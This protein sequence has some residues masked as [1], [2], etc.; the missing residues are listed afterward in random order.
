MKTRDIKYLNKD[1]NS[2]NNTLEQ[3]LKTYFPNTYQDFNPESIG[4]MFIE[5]SSYVGDVLAF[6]LDNQIQENFPQLARKIENLFKHAYVRGYKPKV[7]TPSVSE[8]EIFQEVPYKIVNSER[9]PN[10]EYSLLIPENTSVNSDEIPEINFLT[11]EPIDFGYSSSFDPTI[12][13]ISQIDS[14]NKPETF[15][16]TKKRKIISAKI[17]E[18]SFDV[19]DYERFPSFEINDNNIICILDVKDSDNNVWY[20]V[21]NLS[22]NL[23]PEYIRNTE[24]REFNFNQYKDTP[25]MLRYK[26]IQRRFTSRFKDYNSLILEFGSG[27]YTETDENITPNPYN[28]GINYPYN[29]SGFGIAYSPVNFLF[30]KSYGIA[31]NNTTLTIRYLVGGGVESNIPKNTLNNID[32]TNVS[33]SSPIE[34]DNNILNTLTCNNIEPSTGGSDGDSV[35]DLRIKSMAQ[36]S[37]Q[38]R[39]VSEQDYVI[40]S[41][42]MPPRLGSISKAYIKPENVEEIEDGS[43]QLGLYILGFDNNKKLIKSSKALKQ[44]LKNYLYQYNTLNDLILIK[45]AYIINVGVDF[46]ILIRPGHVVGEVLNN[47]ISEIQEYFNIDNFNINQPILLKEIYL[48]LDKIEGVQTV[49]DIKIKNKV[50]SGEVDEY[51]NFSYDINSATVNNIIYPSID[52]MIFEVKFP[53]IDIRGRNINF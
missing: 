26:K 53:N 49:N 48:L 9:V 6:Y 29:R 37:S 2:W 52:P 38:L 45:D 46:E 22:Q 10:Y 1:F 3:F 21:D 27:L 5:M 31:P 7:S 30:T 8:I 23:I 20:E 15:L 24:Y 18:K 47:C 43:S 4:N 28:I 40:R 42:S 14:D 16:L 36:F 41:L 32:K 13:E 11:Q 25:Y 51:S 50:G 35:K 19:G 12:V 33:F 34:M 44:N 39:G 17:K